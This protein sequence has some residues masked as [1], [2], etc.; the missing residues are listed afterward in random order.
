MAN[1]KKQFKEKMCVVYTTA[2]NNKVE[3]TRFLKPTSTRLIEELKRS[4]E[5]RADTVNVSLFSKSRWESLYGPINKPRAK[6]SSYVDIR[7]MAKTP[8]M[9]MWFQENKRKLSKN[10][11]Y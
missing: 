4:V 1:R 11:A 6:P 8:E 9:K 2:H 5:R 3:R 7:F 10:L